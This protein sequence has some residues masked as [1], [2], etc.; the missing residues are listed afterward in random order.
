MGLVKC[1]GEFLAHKKHLELFA[2]VVWESDGSYVH[3]QNAYTVSEDLQSSWSSAM[4]ALVTMDPRLRKCNKKD[5]SS[6]RGI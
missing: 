3:P 5:P 1:S 6:K 2:M 4:H